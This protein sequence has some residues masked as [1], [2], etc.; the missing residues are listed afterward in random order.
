MLSFIGKIFATGLAVF[1]VALLNP[2]TTGAGVLMLV[3]LW[4]PGVFKKL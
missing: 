3:Y 1:L 2:A 4:A